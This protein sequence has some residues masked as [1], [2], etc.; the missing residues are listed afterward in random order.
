[1]A[2]HLTQYCG[3]TTDL[4]LSSEVN[5]EEAFLYSSSERDLS[6]EFP[7]VGTAVEKQ[8]QQRLENA[9]KDAQVRSHCH[10]SVLHCTLLV[11]V[12]LS[13]LSDF[14]VQNSEV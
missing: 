6:E 1:M 9:R 14:L 4:V 5:E 7:R 13:C 2:K 3:E 11:F 8:R 12:S 10:S